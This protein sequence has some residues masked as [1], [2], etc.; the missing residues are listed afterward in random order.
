VISQTT[1]LGL[2][3]GIYHVND[4]DAAKQWYSELLGMQ[5]Y[6]D[7]PFYVGFEVGGYELGLNPDTSKVKPGAGGTLLYWGVANADS[8]F[9]R[10]IELGAAVV[11]PVADVGGGIR[12]AIVRDPFGNLF[13]VM[14]NPHFTGGR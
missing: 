14:E 5:P 4:L 10:L 11:E 9:A 12:H 3:S 1:L 13:G 6:F 8:A 2:R 7:E